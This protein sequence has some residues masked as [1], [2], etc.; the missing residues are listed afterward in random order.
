MN[1]NKHF[2]KYVDSFSKTAEGDRF[3]QVANKVGL[4]RG[5]VRQTY[6]GQRQVTPRLAIKVHNLTLGRVSKAKLF[7]EYF[8]KTETPAQK[9]TRLLHMEA[10]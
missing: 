2:Q 6:Y 8:A 1:K 4:S 5:T 3:Q 10:A 9:A 7:P